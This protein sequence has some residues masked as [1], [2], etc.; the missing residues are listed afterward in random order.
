[1]AGMTIIRFATFDLE[2]DLVVSL[3]IY[4]VRVIKE[5]QG[6]AVTLT[7]RTSHSCLARVHSARSISKSHSPNPCSPVRLLIMSWYSM[8]NSSII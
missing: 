7:L 8:A 6:L 4:V 3:N 5:K 2:K 1:M